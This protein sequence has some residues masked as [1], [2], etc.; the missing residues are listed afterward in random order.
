M[1]CYNL[2]GVWLE[3]QFISEPKQQLESQKLSNSQ[4]FLKPGIERSRIVTLL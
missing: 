2:T 4:K 3:T 1:N